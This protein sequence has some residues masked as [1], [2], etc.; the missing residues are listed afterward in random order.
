[1]NIIPN[2]KQIQS[3]SIIDAVTNQFNE[4]LK[5]NTNAAVEFEYTAS[6]YGVNL[7]LPA[8]KEN[9]KV[10][11]VLAVG[12]DVRVDKFNTKFDGSDLL[13]KTLVSFL[14]ERVK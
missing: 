3:A 9:N 6:S 8:L 7:N 4:Y 13:Y 14:S 2:T 10:F 1:M 11:S 5:S 12:R